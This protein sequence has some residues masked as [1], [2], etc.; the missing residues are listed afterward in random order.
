MGKFAHATGAAGLGLLDEMVAS[1]RA[2][3]RPRIPGRKPSPDGRSSTWRRFPTASKWT[4]VHRNSGGDRLPR[5]E[6]VP[7][8]RI[9]PSWSARIEGGGGIRHPG[10]GEAATLNQSSVLSTGELRRSETSALPVVP[11][12]HGSCYLASSC[13][14]PPALTPAPRRSRP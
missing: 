2:A 7:P 10:A 4:Q 14:S 1:S 9:S 5:G 6:A 3:P 8:T 11:R 13:R 12:G